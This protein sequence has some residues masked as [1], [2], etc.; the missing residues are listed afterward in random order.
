MAL[1][2]HEAGTTAEEIC[3]KLG[4]SQTTF[5]P[6]KK[7]YGGFGVTELRELRQ[8]RDENRT[9]RGLAADL[10][11][12]AETI[13]Q[14]ALRGMIRPRRRCEAVEEVQLK[15]VS[16]WEAPRSGAFDAKRDRRSSRTRIG[17]G[18]RADRLPTPLLR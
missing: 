9:L 7:R 11:L 3:R 15:S 14:D 12:V 6:W 16:G 10:S 5:S 13:L 4:I 8:L 17:A 1:R 2:Q 18:L